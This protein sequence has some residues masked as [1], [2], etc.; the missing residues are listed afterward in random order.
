MKRPG[1]KDEC[2]ISLTEWPETQQTVMF[3]NI[4]LSYYARALSQTLAMKTNTEN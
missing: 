3:M 1:Q 4:L 2:Y